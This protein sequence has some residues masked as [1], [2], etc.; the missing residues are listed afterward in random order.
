MRAR[1]FQ[2]AAVALELAGRNNAVVSP[3]VAMLLSV[4]TSLHRL[5]E[6]AC[7]RELTPR[8]RVRIKRLEKTAHEIAVGLWGAQ[9]VFHQPDPRGCPMYVIFP[10][11][12]PAGEPV[13]D[14]YHS[15]VAIP[16]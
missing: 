9:T 11:D 13:E 3:D 12:V 15:G 8:E 1:D 5:R 6:A 4:S 2:V 7:L 14:H 16:R 10:G